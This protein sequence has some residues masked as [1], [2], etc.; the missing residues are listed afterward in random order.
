MLVGSYCFSLIASLSLRSNH[1]QYT[2]QKDYSHVAE[3]KLLPRGIDL[4]SRYM[5]SSQVF[6]LVGMKLDISMLLLEIELIGVLGLLLYS[7]YEDY[8]SQS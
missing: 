2:T 3:C 4:C 7:A 5:F 6:V 8:S 1:V